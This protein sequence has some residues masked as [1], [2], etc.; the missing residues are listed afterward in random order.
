MTPPD[1][2]EEEEEEAFASGQ[3]NGAPAESDEDDGDNEVEVARKRKQSI[4]SERALDPDADTDPEDNSR[5]PF[6]P[7]DAVDYDFVDDIAQGDAM[8]EGGLG[9]TADHLD[10][11]DYDDAREIGHEDEQSPAPSVHSSADE[12]EEEQVEE[13]P[14]VPVKR[15]RG[16]PRKSD[17]APRKPVGRPAQSEKFEKRARSEAYSR[18]GMGMSVERHLDPDDLRECCALMSEDLY[19]QAVA[20]V[21]ELHSGMPGDRRSSRRRIPPLAFWRN[22]RVVYERGRKL[23]DIV[24]YD[25]EPVRPLGVAG[26]RGRGRSASSRPQPKAQRK[27]PASSEY[28]SEE[29]EVVDETVP[30]GIIKNQAGHE[31][32]RRE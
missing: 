10:D 20:T 3:V 12:G 27:P 32:Y 16:R 13:V 18:S 31:V 1:D 25:V 17:T 9:E 28:D 30:M 21:S 14:A 19:R 4:R 24:L 2:D 5:P 22:E 15:G 7:G 26:K 8:D 6:E 23:K 29:D 11:G